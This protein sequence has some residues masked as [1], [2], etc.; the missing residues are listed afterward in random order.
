MITTEPPTLEHVLE[1]ARRIR[2]ADADEVRA[3]GFTDPAVAIIESLN[4]SL[5]A[6]AFLIDGELA[7]IFG[8]A[9]AGIVDNAAVPWLITT[10]TVDRHPV[11]FARLTRRV[12]AM[13]RQEFPTLENV[14]DARHSVSVRWLRW[15]GFDLGSSAPAAT[16]VPFHR[17]TMKGAQWA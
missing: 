11:A 8:Y 10:D 14:A 16:G 1:L 15:L 2:P 4:V 13:L 7:C 3:L 9:S 12:L 17:L 6:L 5:S